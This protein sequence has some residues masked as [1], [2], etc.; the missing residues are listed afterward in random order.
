VQQEVW[1]VPVRPVVA[2]PDERPPVAAAAHVPVVLMQP[3]V[4]Q[5]EMRRVAVARVQAVAPRRAALVAQDVL[6]VLPWPAA[7]V[8][9]APAVERQREVARPVAQASAGVSPAP[10]PVVSPAPR[11]VVSVALHPASAQAQRPEP[12]QHAPVQH[13]PVQ[14]AP[15]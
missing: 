12:V 1:L 6:V 14:H 3:A 13:A 15:E 5:D 11:P 10:R 7:A 8:R 4:D 2:K 9:C